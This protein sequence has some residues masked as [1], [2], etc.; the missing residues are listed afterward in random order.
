MPGTGDVLD[1]RQHA[2]AEQPVA[3][4][5]AKL[6]D[7]VRIIAERAVA[8]DAV[9]LRCRHVE[10]RRAVYRDAEI[11]QLRRDQPGVEPRCFARR[12]AVAPGE[13]AEPRGGRRGAPMGRAKPRHAPALLVDLMPSS[14]SG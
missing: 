12:R 10:H 13:I 1:E 4:R 2:A 14:G 7:D 6:A 8:D 5:R 3:D 9:G 11:V